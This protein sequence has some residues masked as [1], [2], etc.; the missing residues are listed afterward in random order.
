META[1][2]YVVKGP[3]ASSN[4]VRDNTN[5]RER[6]EERNRRHQL[7]FA[8]TPAEMLAIKVMNPLPPSP[9]QAGKCKKGK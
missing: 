8:V 1:D 4:T 2:L 3:A 6:Q 9:D 7:A 5:D